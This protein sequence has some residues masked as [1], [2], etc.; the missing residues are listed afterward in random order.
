M[1]ALLSTFDP[2]RKSLTF[3]E[4]PFRS[5]K[6]YTPSDIGSYSPRAAKLFSPVTTQHMHGRV[7]GKMRSR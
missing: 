7:F 2:D 1:F 5:R 4:Q 3:T 6:A